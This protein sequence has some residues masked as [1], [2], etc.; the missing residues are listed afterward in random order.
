MPTTKRRSLGCM[1]TN[2]GEELLSGEDWARV[3]TLAGFTMQ[4]IKVAAY[5]F[6]GMSRPQVA[7]TLGCAHDTVSVY[8][9]R[10]FAKLAVHDR[11]GMGLR[12]MQIHLRT[13]ELPTD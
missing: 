6:R 13:R 9:K 4:E 1:S 7:R 10:I 3:A 12:I 8:V 2:P 5:M 11:L